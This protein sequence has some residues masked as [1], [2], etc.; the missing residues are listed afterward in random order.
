MLTLRPRLRCSTEVEVLLRALSPG[1]N[2]LASP[3][4]DGIFEYLGSVWRRRRLLSGASPSPRAARH[5]LGTGNSVSPREVPG[6]HGAWPRGRSA[7]VLA[8]G[9]E[10]LGR[11]VVAGGSMPGIRRGRGRSGVSDASGQRLS[12]R[13]ARSAGSTWGTRSC[14]P[15]RF[16]P[17]SGVDA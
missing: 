10:V 16:G 11:V 4:G 8:A 1:P 17:R 15:R 2:C 14:G 13:R 9:T 6:K 12:D 5:R 7:R 3:C